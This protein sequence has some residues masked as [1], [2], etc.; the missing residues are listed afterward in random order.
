MDLKDLGECLTASALP[1]LLSWNNW[2]LYVRLWGG[3][4]LLKGETA[5]VEERGAG[6][7]SWVPLT[8]A[9]TSLCWVAPA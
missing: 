3:P 1:Y 7:R 4:V 9:V 5:A 6:P 2:Q 8:R